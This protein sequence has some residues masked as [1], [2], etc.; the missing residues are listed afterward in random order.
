VAKF[1]DLPRRSPAPVLPQPLVDAFFN[2]PRPQKDVPVL[3]KTRAGGQ[4]VVFAVRAA[5]DG[6]IGQVT[7]QERAQL[8]TQ[9]AAS[10]GTQAQEAFIQAVRKHYVIKVAEDRM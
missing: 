6:D 9:V 10:I 8:R 7:P 2:V 4:L 1:E 5:R 3:G